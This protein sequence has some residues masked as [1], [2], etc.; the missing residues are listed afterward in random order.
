M[1]PPQNT[2]P[3]RSKMRV[4]VPQHDDVVELRADQRADQR[5]EHDVGHDGSA[6]C[7]RRAARAAPR[8]ARRRSH[9]DREPEAG[10]LQR[11][12]RDDERVVDDRVRQHHAV[13]RPGMRKRGERIE[14]E[15]RALAALEV[16][17]PRA[18]DHRRVV[19]R[20]PRRR[21]EHL[22]AAAASIALAHRRDE[23]AVARHAAAEHDARPSVLLARRGRS[24]RRAS[25][26]ARPGRR[27]RCARSV[28]GRASARAPR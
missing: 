3:P 23:R 24:S 17:Q 7:P 19:G 5:R 9:Q 11:A 4:P 20:E 2:K 25:R 22:G 16:E 10:E 8:S 27:A 15:R 14:V 26:R 21:R 1:K 18:R 28:V 13:T 12:E 6:S